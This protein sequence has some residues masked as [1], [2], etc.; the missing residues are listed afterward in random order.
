[1]GKLLDILKKRRQD[2]DD[3][4]NQPH[5]SYNDDPEKGYQFIQNVN[6]LDYLLTAS[7]ELLTEAFTK[8]APEQRLKFVQNAF[9]DER[10]TRL[11]SSYFE[12]CAS[13]ALNADTNGAAARD[14]FANPENTGRPLAETLE[15]ME[16]LLK[17]DQ[18]DSVNQHLAVAGNT[19]PAERA[20]QIYRQMDPVQKEAYY[21]QAVPQAK[22]DNWLSSYVEYAVKEGRIGRLL[23][24][25][26]NYRE[27]KTW[28][29]GVELIE[30][31]MDPDLVE[32][33][34]DR[35]SKIPLPD[36]DPSRIFRPYQAR[37]DALRGG[38]SPEDPEAQQK[39]ELLDEAARIL[40]YPT[41]KYRSYLDAKTQQI[42]GQM[43][44]QNTV[45]VYDMV[46]TKRALESVAGGKFLNKLPRTK[47][48]GTLQFYNPTSVEPQRLSDDQHFGVDLTDQELQELGQKGAGGVNKSAREA[49]LSIVQGI[50][51]MGEKNYWNSNVIVTLEGTLQ[52]PKKVLYK[53][54]QGDKKY[55]FWP[56]VNAKKALAK[57]VDEG[58]FARI[59]QATA[60]Y[61]RCKA[62]TD[63][64]M[65]AAN[66]S[67]TVPVFCGNLNSTRSE[68]DHK[69]PNPMPAEY[70]KDYAGHSRVNGVFLLYGLSKN[71]GVPVDHFLDDVGTAMSE[72]SENFKNSKLLSSQKGKS[73]G[74][75][76]VHG[77]DKKR[78]D[79]AQTEWDINMNLAGRALFTVNSFLPGEAERVRFAGLRYGA[80]AAANFEAKKE[81]APWRTLADAE[82]EAQQIVAQLALLQPDGQFDLAEAGRKLDADDWYKQLN[83]VTVIG[84]LQKNGALDCGAMVD[85]SVQFLADAKAALQEQNGGADQ[86]AEEPD[87][88]TYQRAVLKNYYQIMRTVPPQQR[89]TEGYQ[90][91]SRHATELQETLIKQRIRENPE[92]LDIAR[93]ALGSQVNLL[94]TKKEGWFLSSKNTDQYDQMV[95]KVDDYMVKLRMLA[96]EDVTPANTQMSQEKLEQIRGADTYDLLI[97][98]KRACIVYASDKSSKG[99]GTILH[100]AGKKRFQGAKNCFTMLGTT[101]DVLGLRSPAISLRD[102]TELNALVLRGTDRWDK[103]AAETHAAK[104]IYAMSLQYK[105]VPE[106]R[107]KELIEDNDNLK[108][109]VAK[110]RRNTV[111]RQ[112]AKDLGANGLADKIIE[113]TSALTEAY[114]DAAEKVENTKV[115]N[116]PKRTNEQKIEFWRDKPAPDKTEPVQHVG[117]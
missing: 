51:E 23:L 33:T 114:M 61:N 64:M 49:I 65:D 21:M 37:I 3:Y 91:M 53:D 99:T 55:A 106:E 6:D 32:Q 62:A 81:L 8:M 96:G 38:I 19:D 80:T 57:A 42:A 98:A 47:A 105:G 44:L 103:T 18:L 41:E 34:A 66:Q 109:A 87:L 68:Q 89:E 43:G 27:G 104:I 36:Q 88:K 25:D 85:R 70:L 94:K 14:F 48:F 39:K 46:S 58:D 20:V 76:L 86:E 7:G 84:Q 71:T 93:Q 16:G 116:A 97:A 107:Q 11:A 31:N 24:F 117:S 108:N 95:R 79:L 52:D 111:F 15:I 10:Q 54:E 101:A 102:K 63:K 77:F 30:Q 1:M 28:L 75:R 29:D 73:L 74:A 60:E 83:P 22:K 72:A 9:N 56:L 115:K 90:K 110:I 40:V 78:Q 35:I 50:E 5:P 82:P 112:M 69:S 12:S 13:D 92:P 17:Q 2:L 45:D 113:G 4:I 67:T 100:D 26:E 59:R